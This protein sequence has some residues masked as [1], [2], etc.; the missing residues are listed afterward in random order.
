MLLVITVVNAYILKEIYKENHLCGWRIDQ[1]WL[2]QNFDLIFL[3]NFDF[4][5]V[6][7]KFSKSFTWF[8]DWTPKQL[9]KIFWL[10]W[11]KFHLSCTRL[12]YGKIRKLKRTTES[13][14]RHVHGR[15]LKGLVYPVG[16]LTILPVSRNQL[17]FPV[18]PHIQNSSEAIRS[19]LRSEKVFLKL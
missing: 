17:E 12:N 9:K 16:S 15:V 13:R 5:K 4:I 11:S 3:I 8:L 14:V 19:K 7:S 18:H 6:L 1:I 2:D 10:I